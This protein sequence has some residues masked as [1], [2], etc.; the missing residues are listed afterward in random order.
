MRQ[1]GNAFRKLLFTVDSVDQPCT[2][3][4]SLVD[5]T[6]L[7]NLGRIH[8]FEEFLKSSDKNGALPTLILT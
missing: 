3:A 2:L 5:N 8:S 7:K 6:E 1:T 4:Y